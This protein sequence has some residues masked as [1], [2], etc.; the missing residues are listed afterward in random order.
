[1]PPRGLAVVAGVPDGVDM[2]MP[3][4]NITLNVELITPIPELLDKR[5]LHCNT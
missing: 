5:E 2:V 1:M 4:D 3:G